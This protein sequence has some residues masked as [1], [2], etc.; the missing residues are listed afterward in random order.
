MIKYKTARMSEN[1]RATNLYHCFI[2][3]QIHNTRAT[4]CEMRSSWF[5]YKISSAQKKFVFVLFVFTKYQYWCVLV[6]FVTKSVQLKK[7]LICVFFRLFLR[8][9][10]IGAFFLVLLQNKFSARKVCLICFCLLLRGL[11]I[12]AVAPPPPSSP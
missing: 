8:S 2:N 11:N 9:I 4:H 1:L 3:H 12:C 10:N 7:S 6:S 5:C